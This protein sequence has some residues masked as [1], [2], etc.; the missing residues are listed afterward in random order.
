VVFLRACY[1]RSYVYEVR[2]QSKFRLGAPTKRVR[3]FSCRAYTESAVGSFGSS[4]YLHPITGF[5]R[6]W[7]ART[8]ARNRSVCIGSAID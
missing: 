6:L 2:L 7:F 5:L 8:V 1:L 3:L 4:S